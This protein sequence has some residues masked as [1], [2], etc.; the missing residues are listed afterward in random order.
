[1]SSTLNLE[2][3]IPE[4][5]IPNYFGTIK[6]ALVLANYSTTVAY[7]SKPLQLP[8]LNIDSLD[9]LYLSIFTSTSEVGC[10]EI[11]FFKFSKGLDHKFQVYENSISPEKERNQ[12]KVTG[13]VH[14]IIKIVE[15]LCTRCESLEKLLRNLQVDIKEIEENTHSHSFSS[16]LQEKKLLGIKKVES[17][18]LRSGKNKNK[19]Y[20]TVIVGISS[21]PGLH[22]ESNNEEAFVDKNFT[23][24]SLLAYTPKYT[25]DYDNS[26]EGSFNEKF[27]AEIQKK[28]EVIHQLLFEKSENKDFITNLNEKIRSLEKTKE[29]LEKK[30]EETDLQNF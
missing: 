9:K 6:F 19:P 23:E 2:L 13:E 30:L 10:L 16:N 29:D 14:V 28:D 27:L 15:N 3:F 24:E 25:I 17:T 4:I 1:M 7:P 26:I 5:K 21:P 22:T 18:P 8:N 20:E 12:R 11:P